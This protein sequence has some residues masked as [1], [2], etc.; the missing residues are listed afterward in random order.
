MAILNKVGSVSSGIYTNPNTLSRNLAGAYNSL[1]TQINTIVDILSTQQRSPVLDVAEDNRWTYVV[2]PDSFG[3]T[4]NPAVDG[5]DGTTIFSYAGSDYGVLDPIFLIT[6]PD[7]T[8]EKRPATLFES[9]IKLKQ[10]TDTVIAQRSA[11][12]ISMVT[13]SEIDLSGADEGAVLQN[14]A[15]DVAASSWKFMSDAGDYILRAPG[16]NYFVSNATQIK[17]DAPEIKFVTNHLILTD[18]DTPPTGALG[19]VGR[20]YYSIADAALHLVDHHG[21]DI[22]LGEAGGGGSGSG[23]NV[24]T[25]TSADGPYTLANNHNIILVDFSASPDSP[26]FTLPDSSEAYVINGYEITIADITGGAATNN[27]TILAAAGDVIIGASSGVAIDTNF[28]LLNLKYVGSGSW[29]MMF[30]R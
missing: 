7:A 28:G 29:L 25:Y 1:G 24:G 12:I 2:T 9:F 18:V 10:Y 27:I 22:A 21:V 14:L 19:G 17:L 15:G 13:G 3:A 23:A 11:A 5:L 8:E 26:T 4:L 20:I 6:N 16:G 30:G